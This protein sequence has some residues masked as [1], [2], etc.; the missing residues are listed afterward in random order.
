MKNF[1]MK[2]GMGLLLLVLVCMDVGAQS[3]ENFSTISGAEREAFSSEGYPGDYYSSKGRILSLS[4]SGHSSV[5]H[6][7][8]NQV[9]IKI[10]TGEIRYYDTDELSNLSMDKTTNQVTVTSLAGEWKDTYEGNV[11]SISFAKAS[12]AETQPGTVV[13]EEGKVYIQESEGWLESAMVKF[14]PYNNLT[15]YHVY[16][17]GEEDQSYRQIDRQLVRV[18]KDYYRADIVG[19]EAGIYSIKIVPVKDSAEIS[20]AANEVTDIHVKNYQ[21][22]GFAHFN[23]SGVGAYNDDGSL[24]SDARVIYVTAETAKTVTCSV[25][26]GKTEEVFTGLQSIVNAYQKGVDTRPLCV[27]LLGRISNTDMDELLSDEGLQIKGKNNSI[28]MNITIE[29][30]GDDA[31]LWGFGILLRNAL[32]VELRNFAVMLCMDDCISIDTKNKNLWIHHLDLFYG[33]T[34]KDADQAKG[35]GATDLKGNSQYITIAYNHYFDTGKSSLCGLKESSPNYITFDHNWFDHSDSRHPRVRTM[36][37]HVYNNYYDGCAKYGVGA[38]M[39]S[40]VFV[41]NNFFR[42][43]RNPMLISMQGTDAKGDGTFSSE[44]GG[45]IKSCGNVYA[46]IDSTGCIP[47]TQKENATSFDCYEVA[48]RD[49]TVPNTYKTLVGGTVYNNFDTDQTKMYVYEADLAEDVPAIVTG[50]YGAGR[51]NH[52]DFKWTFDNATEDTDDGVIGNLKTALQ[53][54]SSLLIGIAGN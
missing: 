25:K 2:C 37:V 5:L 22:E 53:N 41:E 18:Y 54:Y 17:R 39:A 21:R 8:K 14:S 50:W 49:D 13:N 9:L 38:T 29:G 42:H 47:I 28:P 32:S 27:R 26:T 19:L 35:D 52:G 51:M 36:S 4:H 31:T 34:G 3:S 43:S 48:M 11:S 16:I 44:D 30:I 20:S 23:Y 1:F 7:S 12:S 10:S 46:E 15:D 6:R 40:S 24:K 45:M 33:N